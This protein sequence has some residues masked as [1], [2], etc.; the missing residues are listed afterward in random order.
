M[1]GGGWEDVSVSELS[2]GGLSHSPA[3]AKRVMLLCV[4]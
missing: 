1:N 2:D 3:P 4:E